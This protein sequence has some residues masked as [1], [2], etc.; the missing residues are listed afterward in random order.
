[1]ILTPEIVTI[2]ILNTLFAVFATITFVISVRILLYWR[3]DT[4]TPLQYK[5]QL[6]RYL[7][8]TIIKFIFYTKIPL[9]IFF[10]YTLDTLATLL[11]GAMCGAGVVNA[12]VYGTPLLF[13]KIIN[14]YLF[15]FWI[16]LHHQ[17]MK[18]KNQKYLRLKFLLFVVFYLLLMG[19]IVMEM[20]MFYSIDIL[21]VVDCCGA[22]F[23][24]TR[25]SYLSYLLSIKGTLVV[26]IFYGVYL[27]MIVGYLVK[28]RYLFSLA[29]LLFV[30]VSL[31]SLI[32]FFGTYI[33][34]QP[35]HHC[36]FCMLQKDY[37][38]IGYF[39][40]IT[41]FLGTF[42]GLVGAF[43]DFDKN[44]QEKK[45]HYALFFNSVYVALVSYFVVSFYVRNGVWLES[46][47]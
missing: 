43:V 42:N 16:V 38:Y 27:G 15:A 36:P 18:T 46:L 24:T 7:A 21:K 3:S 4:S 34:E 14:I 26:F 29:N 17:D 45:F 44:T 35:T 39:L 33:Y 37:Y 6:Q 1:M 47:K 19:E 20:M 23:Q 31:L 40:Y 30:I 32:T 11:P 13:L 5:L 28:N 9:F 10:I 25:N 22:I 2:E 12:T 41:L 8:A